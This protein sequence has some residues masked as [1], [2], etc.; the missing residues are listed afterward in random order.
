MARYNGFGGGGGNMQNMLR[1]AQK[2]QEEMQKAQETL[3][4]TEFEGNGGGE[5]VKVGFVDG[6][7]AQG[8]TLGG[9]LVVSVSD[10]RRPRFDLAGDTT[11]P[12]GAVHQG[13]EDDGGAGVT[14]LS[15]PGGDGVR[16]GLID[17]AQAVNFILIAEEGNSVAEFV[18]VR[19]VSGCALGGDHGLDGFNGFHGSMSFLPSVGLSVLRRAG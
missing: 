5:L 12:R 8:K 10:T 17:R 6:V 14:Y 13:R 7:T 9:F 1:Q 15:S 3:H 2:I 18:T 19:P 11:I 4:S 16:R